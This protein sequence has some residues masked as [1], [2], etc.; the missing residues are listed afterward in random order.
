MQ[1]RKLPFK[2]AE[3]NVITQWVDIAPI[4]NPLLYKMLCTNLSTAEMLVFPHEN[5][6]PKFHS[7]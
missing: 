2:M 5:T 4:D 6:A 7:F 1:V 3:T